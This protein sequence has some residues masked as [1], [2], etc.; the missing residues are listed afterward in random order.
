MTTEPVN[1]AAAAH[2]PRLP[3]ELVHDAML[4]ALTRRVSD[5]ATG[6]AI[7][8]RT[9]WY[10]DERRSRFWLGMLHP[11]AEIIEAL[12]S[13]RGDLAARFTPSAQGFA[14]RLAHLPAQL[15]VEVNLAVWLALHPTLD[16]Q[17]E[18]AHQTATAPS[19]DGD[20]P[21]DEENPGPADAMSAGPTVTGSDRA[22]DTGFKLAAAWTKI[23]VGPVALT[24]SLD[25]T[26]A[27]ATRHGSDVL[28]AAIRTAVTHLPP[29]AEPHRPLRT[30][31]PRA[32]NPRA[33]DLSDEATWTAYC[34]DNLAPTRDVALP[35]WR[36]AL[37]IELTPHDDGTTTLLLT[38]V[39]TGPLSDH[40]YTDPTNAVAYRRD[41]VDPAL[42]E[43]R[44]SAVPSVPIIP[45]TLEQISD[46]YRYNRH[47]PG[48]GHN[49]AL[50]AADA[51]DGL[52]R[53]TT[54]HLAVATTDR[55]EPRTATDDGTPID[56]SFATLAADPL[57]A[58]DALADAA[59]SWVEEHWSA[60]ALDALAREAHWDWATREKADADAVAA[61]E[62][63]D[64]IRAGISALRADDNLLKAFQLANTSMGQVAAAKGYS[65]WRPFQ[66]AWI[67]GCLPGVADLAAHRSEVGI[68]WFPTGGG[69]TEAYLGLMAIVLFYGRLTG[70][71]AGAQVW[72][73]FPLRLLSL[74]QTER[75]AQAVFAAEIV[76]RADPSTAH[77]APF[78]VG[79]FVGGG[80]TPN[81]LRI[82]HP[83]DRY[84]SGPDPRRKETADACRVLETCPACSGP[85]RVEVTWNDA[86]QLM[87]HR[88]INPACPLA[89]TLPVWSVD[90]NIYRT[91]PS[92][93]VGTVDKLAQ[94][95]QNSEFRVLLGEAAARCPQHGYGADP[96]YCAIFGCQAIRAPVPPGFGSVRLEIADEMHLLDESLGALDGNYETLFEAISERLGRPPMQIVGAT[97]TIEGYREQADHLYRRKDPRRFPAA[98]PTT[99]ETFWAS[100]R[101]G[102]PLRRYVG[103][104]PRRITMVT[105]AR[106]I[107]LAHARFRADI[108][109][110]PAAVAAECGLPPSDASRV[111][112]A[113][114]QWYEVHT[115]YGLR[116]DELDNYL[117]DI[118]EKT[119]LIATEAN[120]SRITSDVG[121]L[122]IRK[123]LERLIEPP[124]DPDERIRVLAATRAISHGVDVS[125]LGIMTVMGMPTQAAEL[126]QAS[127]RVGRNEPGLVLCLIN[128]MRDRDTSV[129]RWFEK[130]AS[131][132]DRLVH[133]V[134]VNRESLPV[135]QRVLPGGLMAWL[136]QKHESEW[137]AGGRRR[138]KLRK[139]HA[140][141][142]ALNAGV[143]DEPTLIDELQAGFGIEPDNLRHRRHAEEIE[144]FVTDTVRKARLNA[145]PDRNMP[146]LLDQRPPTSLRDIGTT[147][148][149]RAEL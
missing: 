104:L 11:E 134:P 8:A 91:A 149:L 126:I 100:V 119:D 53:L 89:G 84:Y 69:K 116:I 40:Q 94:L 90:R 28:A 112:H 43:V 61:H 10:G 67:V 16:E 17:R 92:V 101:K 146:D 57:P 145:D 7:S 59:E 51:G 143:I 110:D 96:N 133:K 122:N 123:D 115:V 21:T 64:W 27:A 13:G 29:G 33:T 18:R 41:Y 138:K 95:G 75:F 93:L 97:A 12:S 120:T 108:A 49:S 144:K 74:Q 9:R 78:A 5:A 25:D 148:E 140:V 114:A 130:W 31:L 71:T 80:N 142:E 73:R 136:Y 20:A 36:A 24:V 77:G 48:F 79:Y 55:V 47:V 147:I 121:F 124:A 87:E 62:E 66:L 106:E 38:V 113:A 45:H 70:T 26:A 139:T 131:Y 102:R 15:D 1:S 68:L 14:V 109:S 118:S 105:A 22:G 128:P 34:R 54:A 85:D 76:R 2:A 72:A 35:E 82:P 99:V 141:V 52:T 23:D 137:L 135:L 56:S 63:I 39:N 58:L 46:S 103:I 6:A 117:R 42:Y 129:F 125:R 19:A 107:T 50:A 60:T 32:H 30:G 127:A 88:C 86:A 65:Q 3:D 132:L 44:L 111:A 37:D 98:G 81:D 4:E 83:G